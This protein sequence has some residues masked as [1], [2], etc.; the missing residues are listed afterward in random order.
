MADVPLGIRIYL[1][2]FA[3]VAVVAASFAINSFYQQRMSS[4]IDE[5]LTSRVPAMESAFEIQEALANHHNAILTFLVTKNR[6]KLAD[7]QHI[8]KNIFL[9]LNKLKIITD[10]PVI[11]DRLRLL[12]KDIELYF[13]QVKS[14]ITISNSNELPKE[15]G[16]FKT[17]DWARNQDEHRKELALVSTE[18]QAHLLHVFSLCHEIV[19]L[20]Q[21]ELMETQR[22]MDIM[23]KR[24]LN[25]ALMTVLLTGAFVAF[26]AYGLA[27]SLLGSL[28][29]LL[30]GIR[31]VN[32][33]NLNLEIPAKTRGILGRLSNEFNRMAR[34]IREQQDRL[35]LQNITDELSGAYNQRHFRELLKREMEQARRLNSSLTLLMI[36]LDHFKEYNDTFGHELGNEVIKKVSQT[37][38]EN[39]RTVDFLA[40]Y[41]GDEFAALLPNA[42]LEE[43]RNIA[44]RLVEAIEHCRFPGQENQD[45]GQ[46]TL[47]I[48]GASF[49][50][51]A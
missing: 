3:I 13:S 50:R 40:R 11:L 36:D 5:M 15:A 39:L 30:R 38:R 31:S 18:G 35:F 2:A 34:T 7:A 12:E 22:E 37:V 45:D 27:V 8:S 21:S 19:T 24:N 26:I 44:R 47:S 14:L 17:I 1:T 23:K 41:G 51:D 6:E 16:W 32:E 43:T 48:G 49:P 10:N 42:T 33:G 29:E 46:I 20:N 28:Q 4:E 25:A 9:E